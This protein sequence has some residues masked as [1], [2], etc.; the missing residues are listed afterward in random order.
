MRVK[1]KHTFF[2]IG[3]LLIID[4]CDR[5]EAFSNLYDIVDEVD[6]FFTLFDHPLEEHDE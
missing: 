1:S 2:A 5:F 6:V 3:D 4:D